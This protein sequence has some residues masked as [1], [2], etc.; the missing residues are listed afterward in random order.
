[1]NNNK[2]NNFSEALFFY[3]FSLRVVDYYTMSFMFEKSAVADEIKKRRE[4]I[5]KAEKPE[6]RKEKFIP[7]KYS[8]VFFSLIQTFIVDACVFRIYRVRIST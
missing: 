8:S 2:K 7:L 3:I 1:M 6:N 5:I 4:N